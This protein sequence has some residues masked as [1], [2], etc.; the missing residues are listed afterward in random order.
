MPSVEAHDPAAGAESHA[1]PRVALE[2]SMS[3]FSVIV[4]VSS[5]VFEHFSTG[6]IIGVLHMW[7]TVVHTL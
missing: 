7:I 5:I 3:G 4:G 2:Q 6:A 1:A